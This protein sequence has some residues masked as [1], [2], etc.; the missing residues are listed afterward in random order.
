M[1]G[2]GSADRLVLDVTGDSC[3]DGGGPLE[4]ASFTG[5]ARFTVRYGT[6]GYAH[7]YGSGQATFLEDAASIT[8]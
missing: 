8:G 1:L 7:A 6:G 5:L 3:Q 4:G 2:A